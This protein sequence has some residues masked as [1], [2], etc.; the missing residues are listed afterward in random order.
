MNGEIRA[1]EVEVKDVWTDD[2]GEITQMHVETPVERVDLFPEYVVIG[3]RREREAAKEQL[4]IALF[5]AETKAVLP[6]I[7]WEELPDAERARF[8]DKAD[9]L[10]EGER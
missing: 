5:W 9:A 7:E 1:S 4:A 2:D 3:L 10:L 6:D 8:R